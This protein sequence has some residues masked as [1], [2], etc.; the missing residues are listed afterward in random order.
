MNF[1][2]PF[3]CVINNSINDIMLNLI[4]IIIELVL[5]LV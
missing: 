1:F 4:V 3:N 2:S 5:I